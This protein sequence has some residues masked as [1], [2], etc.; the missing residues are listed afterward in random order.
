MKLLV[1]IGLAMTMIVGVLD[2]LTI[3]SNK[4]KNR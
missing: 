2:T 1:E 3:I 4:Y